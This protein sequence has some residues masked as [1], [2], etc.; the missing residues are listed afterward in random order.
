ML[1]VS[2]LVIP[3]K[4]FDSPPRRLTGAKRM[5]W[6]FHRSGL[7]RGAMADLPLEGK[8]KTTLG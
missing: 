6:G 1:A 5:A 3:W 7:F 8:L 4:P 2:L